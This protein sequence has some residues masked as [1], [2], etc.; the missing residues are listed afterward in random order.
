M[1]ILVRSMSRAMS[2]AWAPP[3][4]LDD[5]SQWQSAPGTVWLS[6]AGIAVTPATALTVSTVWGCTR[7]IGET[8]ASIP[9][10]LYE[11]R[12]DD[13]KRRATEQPLYRIL[14]DDPNLHQT[15][16]SWRE[17]LTGHTCLRGNGL[18]QIISERGQ[19][20]ELVPL[21]PD[22]VKLDIT[23]SGTLRY[24]VRGDDGRDKPPLLEDEV[25]HLRGPS[26]NGLVGMS[27]VGVARDS[28]GLAQAAESH[29]NRTFRNGASLSGVLQHPGR[30]S[31]EAAKRIRESWDETYSGSRSACRARM[32]SGWRCGSSRSK[33]PRAGSVCRCT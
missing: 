23:E 1:T 4:P 22:R 7:V 11:R 16:M 12:N 24:I 5:W 27:V 21:H 31:P 15:S 13:T 19:I 26:D 30:L 9:L 32:P 6:Q 28:I 3:G 14:H 10:V 2:A 33:K 8:M 18:S 29:G 20:V 17:M 25:F